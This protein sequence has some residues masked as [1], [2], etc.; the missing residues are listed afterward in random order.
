M[1]DGG[2]TQGPERARPR[3]GDLVG[4]M[5]AARR[6]TGPIVAILIVL[7][8]VA[9]GQIVVG[10]PLYLVLFGIGTPD[11][12]GLG[13]QLYATVVLFGVT[14]LAL[15]AWVRFKEVRPFATVGFRSGPSRIWLGAVTGL[16][17]F[18]VIVLVAVA[19][20]Q[21]TVQARPVS[22]ALAGGVLVALAGFAVQGSTE[23]ILTRGYLMQ[24][25]VRRWGLVAGVAVQA[26]L[27]TL[28]HGLNPGT[29]VL[30]LV[31]LA[32]VAVFLAGWALLEGGLWG[33]CAWHAVWNWTQ[34]NVWGLLVSGQPID[35]S[36]LST[37]PAAGSSVLLTGG[38]FGPEGSVTTTVV[39]LAGIGVVAVLWRRGYG[40]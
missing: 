25:T 35:T 33:V 23:E 34:G 40:T 39:L 19:A 38:G 37:R 13:Y 9:I 30:P 21:M 8:A 31:N 10:V 6:P 22:A 11:Q 26:V 16:V 27:F 20:G 5:D 3:G 32:L 1:L 2:H 24:A 15:F 36:L 28:L 7:A 29:G 12:G 14:S 4:G 17:M 18:A